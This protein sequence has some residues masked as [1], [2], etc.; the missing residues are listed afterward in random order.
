[1]AISHRH[2]TGPFFWPRQII[3]ALRG[4]RLAR[5]QAVRSTSL[6]GLRFDGLYD[7]KHI[8]PYRKKW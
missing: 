1:M 2:W 6:K 7:L 4:W 8:L 5:S 3:R